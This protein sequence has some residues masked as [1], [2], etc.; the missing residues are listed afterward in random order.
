MK[1][2]VA[3]IP[4][5]VNDMGLA[6]RYDVMPLKIAVS[7]ASGLVGRKLCPLLT[8]LGHQVI[9]L[10]RSLDRVTDS[11]SDQAIAPWASSEEAG[12]LSGID[13]VVHLAGQPIAERRWSDAI[14]QEIR[15]SRIDLTRQL[16]KSLASLPQP[17]KV[18]V[19]ASAIGIYG[20]RGDEVLSESSRIGTGFLANVATDW[21]QAC[22]PARRAGI[23]VANARLG[24]VLDSGGGALAKMLTPAKFCGGSLGNGRQWWSWISIDDVIGSIYH[25][26]CNDKVVGPYNVTAPLAVTNQDFARTLARVV[27]RWALFPAPAF[28]LRLTLGEM[29]N[30]LLLSSTHVVP[31]V[32][33]QTGYEFQFPRL[34]DALQSCLGQASDSHKH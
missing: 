11:N 7:G 18:F 25:A 30:S 24:V 1:H 26:I 23:R 33:Q 9:R 20:D 31:N 16:A 2:N 19:C 4:L 27:G 13:A 10:E 21:E 17:P 34:E 8:L 3:S 22:E 28:V 5:P 32:L 29:A 6:N 15:D 14:K 12:K